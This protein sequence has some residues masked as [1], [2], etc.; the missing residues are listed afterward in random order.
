M[1]RLVHLLVLLA[2]VSPAISQDSAKK[3]NPDKKDAA[4]GALSPE[5]LGDLL[6]DLGYEPKDIS[7]KK[8]GVWQITTDRNE[9]KLYIAISLSGNGKLLWFSVRFAA[10]ADPDSAPASAW[11]K[12]LELSEAYSPTH[13]SYDSG[14]KRIEVARPV[15]NERITSAELRKQLDSFDST[16]RKTEP[17]WKSANFRASPTSRP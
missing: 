4:P 10:L 9:W 2:A 15:P 8:T 16:V 12:L 7:E 5:G 14:T 3:D 6:R 1:S 11:L 13:F 17:F